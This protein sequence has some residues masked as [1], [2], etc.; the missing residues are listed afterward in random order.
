ML[1]VDA[2]FGV[3]FAEFKT[4]KTRCRNPMLKTLDASVF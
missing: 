3:L 1:Y 2:I 4:F